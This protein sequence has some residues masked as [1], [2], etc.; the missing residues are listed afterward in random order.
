MSIPRAKLQP[1]ALRERLVPRPRYAIDAESGEELWRF[2]A[3]GRLLTAPAVGN[4]TLYLVLFTGPA[5][6]IH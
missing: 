4:G 3:D 1:P 2:K 5:Y 6:A